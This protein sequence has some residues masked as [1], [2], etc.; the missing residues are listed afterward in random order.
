M[1]GILELIGLFATFLVT[2]IIISYAFIYLM[3]WSNDRTNRFDKID[4]D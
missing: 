1:V 3:Q 2:V 4:L